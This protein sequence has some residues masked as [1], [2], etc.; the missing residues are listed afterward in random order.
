MA[1]SNE[2]INLTINPLD[3]NPSVYF[4]WIELEAIDDYEIEEIENRLIN[5][6]RIDRV[7]SKCNT[8]TNKI[9]RQVELKQ[10]GNIWT[11]TAIVNHDS[12][13][14]MLF[15]QRLMLDTFDSKFKK[16]V[17]KSNVGGYIEDIIRREICNRCKL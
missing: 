3:K 7:I 11:L 5:K 4:C 8:D 16:V 6:E 9:S 15:Y 12:Y 10:M 17:S 14:A 1:K 2:P 13:G